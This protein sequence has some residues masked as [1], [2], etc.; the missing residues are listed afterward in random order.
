MIDAVHRSCVVAE[1][2]QEVF[3]MLCAGGNEGGSGY[4]FPELLC[5]GGVNILGMGGETEWQA[6]EVG[7]KHGDRGW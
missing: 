6:R 5:M 2:F 7:R 3:V 1:V 4:F